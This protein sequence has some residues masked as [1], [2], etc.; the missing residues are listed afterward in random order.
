MKSQLLTPAALS[1]WGGLSN[2]VMLKMKYL[3]LILISLLVSCSEDRQ[4]DASAVKKTTDYGPVAK[5]APNS[6]KDLRNQT[7]INKNLSSSRYG[8]TETITTEKT[9]K[10]QGG[11]WIREGRILIDA[12][13][14]KGSYIIIDKSTMKIIEVG[15]EFEKTMLLSNLA[16]FDILKDINKS[17]SVSVHIFEGWTEYEELG[18]IP[19]GKTFVIGSIRSKIKETFKNAKVDNDVITK[20]LSKGNMVG[21]EYALEVFSRPRYVFGL[22]FYVQGNGIFGDG[23]VAEHVA[24]LL[25]DEAHNSVWVTDLKK[26]NRQIF[27]EDKGLKNGAVVEFTSSFMEAMGHEYTYMKGVKL[28]LRK[29]EK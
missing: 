21:S 20:F 27:F 18:N 19:D 25:F 14:D 24:T 26:G 9:I 8:A 3:Y 28:S 29:E 22:Q 23:S 17:T 10:L 2:A 13:S 15:G 12:R 1:V 11:Y 4:E 6:L 7:L 5:E 16:E